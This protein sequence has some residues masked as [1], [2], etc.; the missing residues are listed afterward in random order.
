MREHIVLLLQKVDSLIVKRLVVLAVLVE[1]SYEKVKYL[2]RV[3]V[4]IDFQYFFL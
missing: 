3:V 4:F 2:F 1:L